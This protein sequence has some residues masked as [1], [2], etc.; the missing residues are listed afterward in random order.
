MMTTYTSVNCTRRCMSCLQLPGRCLDSCA[1]HP[2]ATQPLRIYD[3]TRLDGLTITGVI[4]TL[5]NQPQSHVEER[6]APVGIPVRYVVIIWLG[7]VLIGMG[8]AREPIGLLI[9]GVMGRA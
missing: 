3:D 1:D 6:P 2:D 4:R 9:W 8:L 7:L 5:S